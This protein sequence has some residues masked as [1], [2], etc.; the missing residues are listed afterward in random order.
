M[1]RLEVTGWTAGSRETAVRDWV[2]R[3]LGTVDHEIRVARAAR[4]IFNLT[5]RWHA[6][7]AAESKLLVLA[8][9]VH[10]VGR[11]LGEKKHAARGAEMILASQGLKLGETDRRRLAYL[12][13]HHKGKPPEAAEDGFLD[14]RQEDP[15]AMRKLL[16]MLRAADGLD[17]RWRGGPRL[18]M[19]IE[20]VRVLA[21]YGYVEGDAAEA[22]AVYGRRKKFS[23]LEEA[24]GCRVR[25]SWFG[26]KEMGMVG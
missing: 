10:D 5:A 4:M 9:L 14:P 24:L 15:E 19:T 23:L 12:T 6:L 2:R 17:S 8:A 21:I 13:R 22:E 1:A 20:A 25:T 3:R 18:V 16:G 7:G 26:M 11:A